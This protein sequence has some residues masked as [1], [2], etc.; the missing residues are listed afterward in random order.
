VQRIKLI[1]KGG[2]GSE[3]WTVKIDGWLCCAKIISLD[4]VRADAIESFEKEIE[5][6]QHLPAQNKHIVQYLGFQRTENKIEVFMTLYE[7]NLHSMITEKRQTQT[8]FSARQ[9]A[10]IAYQILSALVVLHS[11]RLIHRDIKSMNVFYENSPAE[12]T[13]I[14]GDFGESKIIPKSKTATITGTARWMAPEVLTGDKYSF[15]ADMWSFGMLLYELMA[16]QIPYYEM[17]LGAEIRII[18]GKLPT[19]TQKQLNDYV[20]LLNVWQGCLTIDPTE[21]LT[22]ARALFLVKILIDENLV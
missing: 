16:L 12:I 22:A 3:V 6:L 18:E 4:E 15:E 1:G 5:I 10:T 8:S 2:S 14:L 19:L 11:R 13:Y 7:G 9:I 21:R 20:C 17:R